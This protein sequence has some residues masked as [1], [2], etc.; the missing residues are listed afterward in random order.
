LSSGTNFDANPRASTPLF[1]ESFML[2]KVDTFNSAI[3]S[4]ATSRDVVRRF[5]VDSRF[6][7][8][9]DIELHRFDIVS[10]DS[11]GC[12]KKTVT[13]YGCGIC[14]MVC[15]LC[16]SVRVKLFFCCCFLVLCHWA[17]SDL[18]LLPRHPR[19]EVRKCE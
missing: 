8:D 11:R 2:S 13:Q 7:S 16:P 14:A 1:E 6:S 3:R 18:C 12:R 19:R 4:N 17:W 10:I 15:F 5:D 9:H